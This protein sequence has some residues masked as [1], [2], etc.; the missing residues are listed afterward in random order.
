MQEQETVARFLDEHDLRV[1]PAHRVLDLASEV[2]ELAKD[3][4]EASEYG[5]TPGD[6]AV[7]RGELGDALFC[8][9]A[10]A[11]ECEIDAG[12]ALTSAIETYEDRLAT[13]STPGSGSHDP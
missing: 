9:L 2:G 3:V 13:R 8:V 6:A 4:N 7:T 1:A 10:L 5:S 12:T 11:D